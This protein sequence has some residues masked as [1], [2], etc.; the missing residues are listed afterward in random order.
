MSAFIDITG[1]RFSRLFV[2]SDDGFY[3]QANGSKHKKWKCQ[4]DCGNTVSVL[5]V[6]LRRGRS[7]SCGCFSRDAIKDLNRTHGLS[8]IEIYTYRVWKLMRQRCNNPVG[9]NFK[10]YG[11]RGIK[12]CA[13]WDNFEN[14]LSDMGQR[15][16]GMSIDRIDCNGDYE[17]SNCRWVGVLEQQRNK[18]SN[19]NVTIGGVTMCLTAWCEKANVDYHKVHKKISKGMSVTDAIDSL[20]TTKQGEQL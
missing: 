16:H 1:A 20:S 11:G 6:N 2:V 13:R 12:V 15:P 7:K 9:H 3:Q 17:P 18:R 14:F 5:S 8:Q 4:C 19:R 10:Y